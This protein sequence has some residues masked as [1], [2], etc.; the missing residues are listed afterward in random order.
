MTRPSRVSAW[1]GTRLFGSR[2][3]RAFGVLLVSVFLVCGCGGGGGDT[4]DTGLQEAGEVTVAQQARQGP[5]GPPS[6]EDWQGRLPAPRARSLTSED[7]A[8]GLE[9]GQTSGVLELEAGW[10][11]VSFPLSEVTDL[12]LGEGVLGS[13]FSWDPGTGSYLPSVIPGGFPGTPPGLALCRG[14]CFAMTIRI[15]PRTPTADEVERVESWGGY[16]PDE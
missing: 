16:D 10:N 7:L 14:D 4:P 12:A 9:P 8:A 11:M 5:P 2:C 3:Q 13:V 1:S 6:L 15:W